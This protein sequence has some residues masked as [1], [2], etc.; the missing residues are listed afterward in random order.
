MFTKGDFQSLKALDQIMV[1][2]SRDFEWFSK[3]LLEHL[4]H[5][6]V[7][8]TQKHGLY[9]GDGGVDTVSH[10]NGEKFYGQCKRW[11]PN[12]RG[13]FNGKLPVRIIRE[14]GGCMLRDGVRRG[15]IITTL[16]YDETDKSEAEKMH[17]ALIGKHE[18]SSEMKMILPSFRE[19]QRYSFLRIMGLLVLW[20]FKLLFGMIRAVF[21]S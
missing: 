21:F 10:L 19:R 5:T 6:G 4:G 16:E 17:I 18:I 2:P 11:H 20:P 9:Y 14:L 15:I 8:V 13:C 1:M 3:F 12:F 7:Q